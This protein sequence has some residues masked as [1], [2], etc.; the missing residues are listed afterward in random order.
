MSEEKV[1]QV[2]AAIAAKAHINA[3]QYAA[4]YKQ[5]LED[6][7]GFWA[8]QAESDQPLFNSRKG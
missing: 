6:P 7:Q 3:E 2:P 4:M 8:E 1:Y 5:S